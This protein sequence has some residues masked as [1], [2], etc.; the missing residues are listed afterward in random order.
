MDYPKNIG[1]L[2]PSEFLYLISNMNVCRIFIY[3]KRLNFFI[4]CISLMEKH[5]NT[6]LFTHSCPFLVCILYELLFFQIL[7][8]SKRSGTAFT[9]IFSGAGVEVISEG[10]L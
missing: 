6:N 9:Q 7:F 2:L 10:L 8:S 1:S 5:L 3:N 4:L